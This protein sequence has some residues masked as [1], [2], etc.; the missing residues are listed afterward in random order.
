MPTINTPGVYES[1]D[2]AVF[3]AAVTPADGAD[4]TNGTCKCLF[5]G[6][7]GDVAVQLMGDGGASTV[8]FKNVQSGSLLPLRATRVLA[9]NTNATNILALY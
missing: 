8:V 6:V 2:P 9:T 3:A 7:G 1:S 4:L 5:V